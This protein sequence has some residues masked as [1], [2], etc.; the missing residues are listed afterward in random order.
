MREFFHDAPL[1]ETSGQRNQ[2][3]FNEKRPVNVRVDGTA[4]LAELFPRP[5]DADEY[6]AITADLSEWSAI[7]KLPRDQR[8]G[9]L[10]LRA[11]PAYD[12]KLL[13]SANS[14]QWFSSQAVTER[15]G[16]GPDRPVRSPDE[17]GV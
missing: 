9:L 13:F 2:E 10:A 5:G 1:E 6:P 16:C 17:R 8:R 15:E 12:S 11:G 4:H 7:R 14:H 3:Y